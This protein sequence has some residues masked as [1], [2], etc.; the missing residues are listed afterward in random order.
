[1]IHIIGDY[2]LQSNGLAIDKV[3]KASSVHVHGC[4][5]AGVCLIA[6][7]PIYNILL[8]YAAIALL[9]SHY[10]IDY[11]KYRYIKQLDTKSYSPNGERIIYLTD[12]GIHLFFI[13][14]I[15]Y[16][17]TRAECPISITPLISDIFYTI[18]LPIG[19]VFSW[20]LII[21]LIWK[22]ANITIKQMLSIY[23]PSA[24]DNDNDKKTGSFIG[25]LERLILLIFLS[26]NQ[27]SAI[28]LVL[29][30]KSIARYEKISSEKEFADYFLLGTLLSTA[31]VVVVFLAVI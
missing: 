16:A 6:I 23:K 20:A 22:P 26:I 14:L 21:L 4:I 5:Y 13:S 12:Q 15:A 24:E 17:L 7:I 18:D 27:Y 29:T 28:G 11:I 19:E 3:E 1:M 2:Y 9:V 8:L 25:L 30:A 31:I 10:I